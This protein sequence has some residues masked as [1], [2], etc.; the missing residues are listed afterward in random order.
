MN[1]FPFYDT[2]GS[3]LVLDRLKGQITINFRFGTPYQVLLFRISKHESTIW[4]FLRY[5]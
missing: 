4:W 3:N 5:T 2:I 1:T